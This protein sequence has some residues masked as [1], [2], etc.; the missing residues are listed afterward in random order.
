MEKKYLQIKET[1][2]LN[3]PKFTI[4]VLMP[5]HLLSKEMKNVPFIQPEDES[6]RRT[7]LGCRYDKH[8]DIFI[9][10]DK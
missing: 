2:W 10:I 8:T 9:E 6:L 3:T 1:S 5:K 7:R 4:W